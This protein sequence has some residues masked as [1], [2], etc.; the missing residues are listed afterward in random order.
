MN[1]KQTIRSIRTERGIS[2]ETLAELLEV[3]R[4]R[5]YRLLAVLLLRAS[6]F[7]PQ[8]GIQ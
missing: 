3:S 8:K 4:P 5:N 1:A 6:R 2:Q 7:L